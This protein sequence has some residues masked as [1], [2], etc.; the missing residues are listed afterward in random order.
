ME[1]SDKGYQSF[2]LDPCIGPMNEY[3]TL[4]FTTPTPDEKDIVILYDQPVP[5]L[6]TAGSNIRWYSDKELLNLAHNGNWFTTGHTE[7]GNYTYYVTQTLS[8]C[9]SAANGVS[10]SIV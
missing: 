1:K 10:L 6:Y 9:E 4:T 7:L 3:G 2:L 8:G 5:D